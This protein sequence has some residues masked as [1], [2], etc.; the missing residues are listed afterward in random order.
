MYIDD[1]ILLWCSRVWPTLKFSTQGWS[2]Y[3]AS[4][5]QFSCLAIHSLQESNFFLTH[6]PSSILSKKIR[7]F[8]IVLSS[9]Q[10]DMKSDKTPHAFASSTI[11]NFWPRKM[12]KTSYYGFK[13]SQQPLHIS[14]CGKIAVRVTSLLDSLARSGTVISKWDFCNFLKLQKDISSNKT[15]SGVWQQPDTLFLV[16]IFFQNI[17]LWL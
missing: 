3:P 17:S 15:P 6:W 1:K 9:I 12:R 4:S 5:P 2:L 16:Q 10:A 7:I 11:Q 14:S 8:V 13:G